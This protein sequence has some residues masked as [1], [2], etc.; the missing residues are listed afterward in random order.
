MALFGWFSQK[1]AD[2]AGYCIGIAVQG[3]R[4]VKFTEL[5][6]NDEEP[7]CINTDLTLVGEIVP[8]SYMAVGV[9]TNE[10]EV[11]VIPMTAL[12]KI[13]SVCCGIEPLRRTNYLERILSKREKMIK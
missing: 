12:K 2:R 13:G 6:N 5:T 1:M 11:S 3:N 10:V 4:L 8:N 7:N 9:C